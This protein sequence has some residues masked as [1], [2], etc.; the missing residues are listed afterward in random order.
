MYRTAG[1]RQLGQ[2]SQDKIIRTG[3]LGQTAG[4]NSQDRIEGT[5]TDKSV[6]RIWKDSPEHLHEY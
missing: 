4:Q 2:D 1:P 3:Q 6:L 5:D